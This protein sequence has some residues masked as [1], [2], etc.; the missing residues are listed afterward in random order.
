MQFRRMNFFKGFF[1]H[2]EDWQAGQEYHNQKRSLH[3][4][5]LH[6]PGIV[7]NFLGELD[8]EASEDGTSLYIRPGCAVDA[9]G[10]DLYLGAAVTLPVAPQDYTP[11][12]TIYVCLE[13]D[14]EKTDRR[15]NVANPEYSGHAFVTEQPR[16]YVSE[17][18]PAKS[19]GAIELARVTLA[20]GKAKVLNASEPDQPGPNEIDRRH[21]S[22]AG[23]VV[24]QLG[25]RD[26]GEM[27]SEGELNVAISKDVAPSETDPNVLIE[28]VKSE[29]AGQFYMA[30]AF[31]TEAATVTWRIESSFSRGRVHYRLFF[32]NFGKKSVKVRYRVVR[33]HE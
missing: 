17:E 10:R 18:K 24:G 29:E 32:K 27:V 7:R 31:P 3:N 20:R 8:V 28:R 4:K 25:I 2:A 12:T 9:E 22:H 1:T 33:F 13:Y 14:E 21:V 23:A 19:G 30:S 15:E 16:V 11:P 26:L 5:T 6:R